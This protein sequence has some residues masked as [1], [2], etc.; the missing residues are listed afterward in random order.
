MRTDPLIFEF[1]RVGKASKTSAGAMPGVKAAFG[2][3]YVK[4]SEMVFQLAA[5]VRG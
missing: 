4:A 2:E 3:I 5:L 1:E